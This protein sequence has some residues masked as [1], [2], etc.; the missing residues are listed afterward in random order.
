MLVWCWAYDCWSV[1]VGLIFP[2]FLSAGASLSAF[3]GPIEGLA[4]CALVWFWIGRRQVR[5]C[6]RS[7]WVLSSEVGTSLK[8]DRER[9]A[10][11]WRS[12]STTL[13]LWHWAHGERPFG[14][15][16]PYDFPR[17]VVVE[18]RRRK[19]FSDADAALPG[20]GEWYRQWRDSGHQVGTPGVAVWESHL[21]P[22][23]WCSW[24]RFAG[25]NWKYVL[26]HARPICYLLECFI[27][28]LG[29]VMSCVH[30]VSWACVSIIPLW[31]WGTT[32][33][34]A[35]RASGTYVRMPSRIC[36]MCLMELSVRSSEDVFRLEVEMGWVN[37]LEMWAA[38]I[39]SD[40]STVWRVRRSSAAY[41]GDRAMWE[42]AVV[43]ITV[44]C[45]WRVTAAT[46]GL[47][48][49][50]WNVQ[51]SPCNAPALVRASVWSLKSLSCPGW[52][53]WP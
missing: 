17:F 35:V 42:E 33:F 28:G 24:F 36:S 4:R 21:F 20:T 19:L 32:S 11:V 52:R 45:W 50:A 22:L 44:A 3:D 34:D 29:T 9:S 18:R 41:W 2:L 15:S 1:S 53:E 25:W 43:C 30:G 38:I 5:A 23:Q 27:G 6:L 14:C 31:L 10:L 7:C 26:L 47:G 40:G 12:C 16:R 51:D 37:E 13:C 39:R 8:G 46:E 48:G 49:W